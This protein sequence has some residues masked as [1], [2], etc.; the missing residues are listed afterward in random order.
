VLYL[1]CG[2][3]AKQLVVVQPAV[4][5]TADSVDAAKPPPLFSAH[6]FIPL[7]LTLPTLC[8]QQL[9]GLLLLTAPTGEQ[10]PAADFQAGMV[11]IMSIDVRLG[12]ASRLSGTS[13]GGTMDGVQDERRVGAA[14]HARAPRARTF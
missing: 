14:A 8:A 12:G 5:N 3:P 2:A 4:C 10:V 11:S 13:R 7:F 6:P 9:P 1:W